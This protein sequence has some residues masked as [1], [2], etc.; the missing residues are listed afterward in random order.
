MI[1]PLI[2]L[3]GMGILEGGVED[4]LAAIRQAHRAGKFVYAMK[5][6][7]G[8]N[9]VPNREEALRFI[10]DIDEIDAVVV[11]MVTPLEVDWNVRFASGRPIP[12]EL[13][14]KTALSSKRLSI[15]ALACEGCG[16]CVEQCENDVLSW[17]TARR[18]SITSRASVRLLCAPLSA[19]GHPDGLI[20]GLLR[21]RTS[22]SALTGS[23]CNR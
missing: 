6:L 16:E 2:N 10:F 19:P 1:H 21:G 12:A 14:Q 7:A 23:S 5:S 4:M 11:G 9:F 13:N 22:V 20:P 15:V 18:W 8:G 3:K 17:W